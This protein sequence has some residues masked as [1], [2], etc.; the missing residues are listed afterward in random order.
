MKKTNL[1]ILA[2]ILLFMASGFF[3]AYTGTKA[4][5][6]ANSKTWW[7]TYFLSPKSNDLSFV[8][9]NHSAYTSFHWEVLL[10][11]FP[12]AQGNETIKNN[13]TKN[14]AIPNVTASGKQT[15]I[16]VT[17]DKEKQEIYKNF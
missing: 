16:I 8:I 11:N 12:L 7:T 17:S 9:E 15:S 13:Q 14:I 4:L 3:L 10:E 1:I 5:D 2:T 6:P